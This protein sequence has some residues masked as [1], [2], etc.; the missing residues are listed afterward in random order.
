MTVER[1][2][3]PGRTQAKHAVAPRKECSNAMTI[4]N[5]PCMQCITAQF[6]IATETGAESGP[7][8]GDGREE[9]M[10]R[11]NAHL[12]VHAGLAA[13][14]LGSLLG[15]LELG[16][17]FLVRLGRGGRYRGSGRRQ[18]ADPGCQG[19]GVRPASGGT[20]RGAQASTTEQSER[21]WAPIRRGRR[22][23]RG[24][25]REVGQGRPVLAS[26]AATWT[27]A[28]PLSGSIG[29]RR[30]TVRSQPD[31]IAPPPGVPRAGPG[32]VALRAFKVPHGG[33]AGRWRG[34][35]SRPRRRQR[36]LHAPASS[37]SCAA[38]P[39]LWSTHW[40]APGQL[41]AGSAASGTCAPRPQHTLRGANRNS[42]RAQTK[43][44]PS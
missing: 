32:R 25:G 16:Q 26:G 4:A 22:F 23:S 27:R 42:P 18:R 10:A 5:A 35:S 15:A 33:A 11:W 38:L 2:R 17:E 12:L 28:W 31:F 40:P 6:P 39:V 19:S 29:A 1:P 13:S 30:E 7:A 24:W 20:L 43:D 37:P 36:H 14:K 9:R 3:A 21:C 44:T 8:A 34:G 41:L